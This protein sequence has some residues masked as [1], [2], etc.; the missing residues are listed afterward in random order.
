MTFLIDGKVAGTFSRPSLG[1]AGYEYNVTVF[2]KTNLLPG[3]H[4]LTIQN[5]HIN[6][7]RSLILLDAIL[8]T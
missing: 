1:P 5:G 7:T 6:G 8:Y 3:E 2:S 4:N